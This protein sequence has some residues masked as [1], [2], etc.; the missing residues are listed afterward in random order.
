M[1]IKK[2]F[3][4]NAREGTDLTIYW[5]RGGKKIDT[6]TKQANQGMCRFNEKFMMKTSLEFDTIT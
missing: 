2:L 4:A 3:L 6:R 1:N 5:M